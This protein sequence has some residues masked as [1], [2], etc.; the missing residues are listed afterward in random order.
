MP[1]GGWR[2][3][4]RT[5]TKPCRVCGVTV[6]RRRPWGKPVEWCEPHHPTKQPYQT[7]EERKANRRAGIA[8]WRAKRL[9]AQQAKLAKM[10]REARNHFGYIPLKIWPTVTRPVG[11]SFKEDGFGIDAN[12]CQVHLPEAID[13]LPFWADVKRFMRSWRPERARTAQGIQQAEQAWQAWE[14]A[15]ADLKD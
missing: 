15:A 7:P 8:A 12:T 3:S 2:G 13:V 14:S 1:R 5:D 9:P 4:P 10:L 11:R 6:P